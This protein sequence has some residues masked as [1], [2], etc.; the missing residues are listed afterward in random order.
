MTTTLFYVVVALCV[1]FA[2]GRLRARRIQNQGEALLSSTVRANFASPD[3]HLLNHVTLPLKDDSTQID[4]ILISRFGVFVVETKH[5]NGW[6]F[7]GAKQA[8]WTQVIFKSKFRFQNPI[9]QNLRHVR[10][11]QDLLDFLPP[12]AIRSV[13]VFTWDAEFKTEIPAGV[14]GLQG[15]VNHVRDNTTEVISLNRMQ[16]CVGRLETA[17]LAITGKTD[18]EHVH[19]LER[20]HGRAA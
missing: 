14:F 3:Y 9:F 19:N 20:R 1:G 13:V 10:A 15:F 6:I 16:L 4:H 5:Y 12:D 11:V 2:L 17:R 7:A 18:I 8:T